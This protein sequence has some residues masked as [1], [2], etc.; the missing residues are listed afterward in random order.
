MCQAKTSVHFSSVLIWT[1]LSS[2]TFGFCSIWCL[3]FVAMLACELDLHIGINVP[4]TILSS[5]LAVFFTFAA[6]ASDLLWET[7]TRRRRKTHRSKKR[8]PKKK[9]GDRAGSSSGPWVNGTTSQSDVI[10]Q[11]D[12]YKSDEEDFTE[13]DGLLR[14]R[15]P[16]TGRRSLPRTESV[17]NAQNQSMTTTINGTSTQKSIALSPTV[18]AAETSRPSSEYSESRRSS[19]TGST[20]GSHGLTSIMNIANRSAAPAKN[21][22]IATGEALYVGCTRRNIVK[23]FLWSLAV[24]GMHYVGIAALRIPKGYYTLNPFLVVLSGL[25]CWVVCLVGVILMSRIESHLTQQFLFSVVAS[26]GVAA[27]HFTGIHSPVL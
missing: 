22:F 8:G 4:L 16:Q 3:H 2:L 25:I 13:N 27:M 11:E 23:G 12:G 26:V 5:I 1:F 9:F 17:S 10:Q 20:H 6:L 15:S 7:Y 19:L 24:S 18:S 14:E 21:A